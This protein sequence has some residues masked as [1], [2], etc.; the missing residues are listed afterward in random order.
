MGV[1]VPGFEP[2]RIRDGGLAPLSFAESLL[3]LSSN[4]W[5]YL[6]VGLASS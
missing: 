4:S 3:S 1:G 5:H 6:A 2:R